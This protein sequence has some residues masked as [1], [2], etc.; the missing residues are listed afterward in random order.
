MQ[1][2]ILNIS[3][4]KFQPLNVAELPSWK[5][6]LKAKAIALQLKGTILLS[7]EGVNVFPSGFTASY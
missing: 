1:G 7:Q 4:Y 2:N 5:I 6:E 3:G